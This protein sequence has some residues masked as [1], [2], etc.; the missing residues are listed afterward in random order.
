M[1][2]NQVRRKK[3]S[4]N[5][6]RHWYRAIVSLHK[7]I[8][9]T[10]LPSLET[11]Y[12]SGGYQPFR[13]PLPLAKTETE[14]LDSS[15]HQ[16]D[17]VFKILIQFKLNV[18]RSESGLGDCGIVIHGSCRWKRRFGQRHLVHS[19]P[20]KDNICKTIRGLAFKFERK[21]KMLSKSQAWTPCGLFY[22]QPGVA[23]YH[24]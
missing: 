6:K 15:T 14:L 16:L 24:P 22:F 7:R 9:D 18:S 4:W 3:T 17:R 13:P 11:S 20:I 2:L 23:L 12:I 10:K 5:A 19:E 1:K 8:R 21:I